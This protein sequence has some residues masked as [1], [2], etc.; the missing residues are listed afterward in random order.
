KPNPLAAVARLGARIAAWEGKPLAIGPIF[1]NLRLWMDLPG[2]TDGINIEETIREAGKRYSMAFRNSLMA[3]SRISIVPT[4]VASGEKSNAVPTRAELRCDARI[5]PGQTRDDLERAVAEFLRE[6][7]EIEVD[8]H[9][10]A[11]TSVSPYDH[12]I[13]GLF[14]RALDRT[15]DRADCQLLPTWCTGFTDSRFVR[16]LGTPVYGFQVIE[17]KADPDRLSI[18]CVDE[19]IEVGMLLPCALALGHLA[20]D[21]LERPPA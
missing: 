7:P 13:E 14:K 20:L 6:F 17:P 2:E 3:Q 16:P 19:S 15:F 12:E 5:I 8:I 9:E 1:R 11:A 18:H 21:F 4:I 10:T